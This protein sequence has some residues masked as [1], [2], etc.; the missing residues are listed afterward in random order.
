MPYQLFT[1]FKIPLILAGLTFLSF[2]LTNYNDKPHLQ[3]FF[4]IGRNLFEDRAK[5]NQERADKIYSILASNLSSSDGKYAAFVKDLKSGEVF[6]LSPDTPMTAASIYKLG[7]MYKTFDSLENGDVQEES[8]LWAS[9]DRLDS[10]LLDHQDSQAQA[11]DATISYTVDEALRMMITI[12]DNY[13]ALL[14]AEKLGWR[15]I[16]NYLKDEGIA[17]FDLNNPNEPQATVTSAAQILE[18]IY[19]SQAVSKSASNKMEK[20][21][22]NQTVNDRIPKYLPQNVKVAHKTGELDNVRNDA[23]I[24][25]GQKSD[26]IFVFFSDTLDPDNASETIAQTS[27]DIFNTLEQP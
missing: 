6:T 19:R 9:Q 17:N 3:E 16:D 1:K 24:V 8:V 22:L 5:I 20:L 26:Y 10:L 7:V 27:K 25:F 13:S 18:K 15:K 2:L 12:S 4:I 11:S 14:L 23:G 21:L